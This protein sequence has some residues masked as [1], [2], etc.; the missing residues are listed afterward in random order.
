VI[1]LTRLD[2]DFSKENKNMFSYTTT[3]KVSR[4][5]NEHPYDF[6]DVIWNKYRFKSKIPTVLL[7]ILKEVAK[8]RSVMNL[9][10]IS[11]LVRMPMS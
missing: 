9:M 2:L 11:R 6:D 10:K 1:V 5:K 7:K 8:D 4:I 3:E